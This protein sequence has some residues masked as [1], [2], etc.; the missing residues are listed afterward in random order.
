MNTIISVKS[1]DSSMWKAIAK[2]WPNMEFHCC[3]SIGDGNNAKFWTDKWI[4]GTTRLSELEVHI[5]EATKQW[6]VKDIALPNGEW[7]FD[8]FNI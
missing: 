6:L 5:P 4:D 8:R 7:N 2:S 1:N 3:W